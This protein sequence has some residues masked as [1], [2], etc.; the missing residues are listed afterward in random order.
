MDVEVLGRFFL[1]SLFATA[2]EQLADAFDV[3][4]VVPREHFLLEALLKIIDRNPSHPKQPLQLRN[5]GFELLRLRLDFFLK[6]ALHLTH[7]LFID[8]T[9]F[10]GFLHDTA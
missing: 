9:D 5:I 10:P 2:K 8:R 3:G 7:D 4:D 6:F 1:G